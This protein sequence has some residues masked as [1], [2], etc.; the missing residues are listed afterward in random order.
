MHTSTL[1]KEKIL[2]NGFPYIRFHYNEGLLYPLCVCES[3]F[4]MSFKPMHAL[5]VNGIVGRSTMRAM[6]FGSFCH[7]MALSINSCLVV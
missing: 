1:I 5:Y 4:G 3:L 7:G 2:Y 6:S